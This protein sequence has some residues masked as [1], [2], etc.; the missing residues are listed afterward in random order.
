MGLG[1]ATQTYPT[2]STVS[3]FLEVEFRWSDLEARGAIPLRHP[4]MIFFLSVEVPPMLSIP[5]YFTTENVH[6]FDAI[7]WEVGD[8]AIQGRDGPVFEANNVKFPAFWSQRA[9]DIVASKYFRVVDCERETSAKQ[10]ISRVVN[11]ITAWGCA[12]GYFEYG[13]HGL[14]ANSFRDELTHILLNQYAA[15]NSPVWFNVG[16]QE[17]PQTSACYILDVEDSMESI[18]EWYRQEGMVFKGGSGSGVNLSKIRPKGAPLS[19]GGKASGVMSF[20][21]VAD[22]NAGAIKSGGTT[23]RAAKLLV[24]D[25]EHPDIEDFINAKVESERLAR[26]LIGAGYGNGIEGGAYDQVPWQNANNS[27][28][29]PDIFMAYAV[30]PNPLEEVTSA[31]EMLHKIAM[32][33]WECGDPGLFFSDTVNAW[34][35]TPSRGPIRSGNPCQEFLRPP[36]EACNLAS[37]NLL[38]FLKDD[39]SFDIP[40]FI[41]T[42]DIMI[43]AMDILID[44]S[45]YPTEAIAQNSK[46]YRPLGLGYC[47]LGAFLMAQ[48]LPY[49]SDEGRALAASVTAFMTGQAYKRSAEIAKVKG[50]FAG[51]A[52]NCDV[53]RDVIFKHYT[54]VVSSFDVAGACDIGSESLLVWENASNLGAKNGFRNCQV[55][56]LAPCGTISFMMDCDTTGVEPCLG[57]VTTK[58]LVGGGEIRMVNG[59][60]SRAMKSLDYDES[61]IRIACAALYDGL[62]F[63]ITIG[64][65]PEHHSVFHT[66]LGDNPISWQGHIKMV[67]AVQPFLSGGVSKTINMP[68][69]S[70]V[71]DVF[72]AYVMAWKMGLKA[73]AIYRDGSKGVQPVTV[74][75]LDKGKALNDAAIKMLDEMK[76]YPTADLKDADFPPMFSLPQRRRLPDERSGIT[77]K[78]T[79]NTHE[80]YLTVG[81]YDDN[82]PGELFVRM[83]KEGSTL[84]G[85]MDAWATMVS[86]A[87][88][89]GVPLPVIT[90]K[91]KD[92]QFDPR[93]FTGNPEIKTV[94]SVLDYISR[95]LEKKFLRAEVKPT[96]AWIPGG[97]EKSVQKARE[98]TGVPY[99]H[100]STEPY[101][102]PSDSDSVADALAA[103]LIASMP[104]DMRAYGNGAL[105][106][107]SECGGM[108]QRAG[109]CCVCT[110][111]GTSTGCA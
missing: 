99:L 59:V 1:L 31:Q 24:L 74:V 86:I 85:L 25:V 109:S 7:E 4:I 56:V 53:M 45:S 36:H 77:H 15:F 11:T 93:G 78:F 111:C 57:L 97:D 79:I 68:H 5:R 48:G 6:P 27:V 87:L 12:D 84:G 107:C 88:Q 63:G 21:K 46:D 64:L 40:S 75:S 30:S 92:T 20:A 39:G 37:I 13:L 67:S 76:H 8:V 81:L 16:V 18:L 101:P 100:V 105:P 28:S 49:D 110:V 23:R 82:A 50:A 60:V 58:K 2:T 43:T 90:A 14:Q 71:Q 17:C 32:A 34:H 44:R 47:N 3:G 94:S 69:E 106:L 33:T 66:A 70:T 62:P 104:H 10:M 29:V 73:I 83:S 52:Q 41:H 95:W 38:K 22:T 42:V 80:G 35:T 72:D 102:T 19:G 98:I 54:T 61:A 96:W 65:L 55:A 9:R 91:F 51:Y 108:T 89:Y 26:Y 103:H